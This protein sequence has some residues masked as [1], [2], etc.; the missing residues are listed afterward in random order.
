[1]EKWRFEYFYNTECHKQCS[2]GIVS[3]A[4]EVH[5]YLSQY[6]HSH[7]RGT[8][9]SIT[10]CVYCL[11]LA[12]FCPITKMNCIFFNYSVEVRIYFI[13]HITK[14][15]RKSHSIVPLPKW[16]VI[17]VIHNVTCINNYAVEAGITFKVL[18]VRCHKL[19]YILQKITE[20]AF[21]LRT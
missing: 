1:M 5:V 9:C 21:T 15:Y 20:I 16:T 7:C 18:N 2:L 19:D 13:L 10:E 11:L 14:D 6:K 17:S 8:T 3:H 4:V 12:F